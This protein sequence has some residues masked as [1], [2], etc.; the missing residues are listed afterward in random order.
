MYSKPLDKDV[1]SDTS[2][3]FR[4]LLVTLL[5]GRRPETTE[6]NIDKIKKDAKSLVDAGAKRFGSDEA[7]FNALFCDRSDSQLKA[8]FDE[9]A[10]L[11]GKSI[12][13]K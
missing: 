5:Q 8:I 11:T 13:K 10:E 9:F 2:G 3:E 1:R 7:R 6:G 12:G 4:R